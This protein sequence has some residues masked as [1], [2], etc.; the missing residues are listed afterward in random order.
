M[1][2]YTGR[3]NNFTNFSFYAV[4]RYFYESKI[5]T[6]ARLHRHNVPAD[7]L[8]LVPHN[9]WLFSRIC[10]KIELWVLNY[11]TGG[12]YNT[13]YF[14]VCLVL[15]K[16]IPLRFTTWNDYK[17]RS[18]WNLKPYCNLL[19]IKE[20]MGR[21]IFNHSMVIKA[22]GHTIEALTVPG[23]LSFDGGKT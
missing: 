22:E 21:P 17:V 14:S 18:I 7:K 3:K 10:R 1:R 13:K 11:T 2:D 12:G 5:M 20:L 15:L 16:S 8:F 4:F 6:I 23:T 9:V 19:R